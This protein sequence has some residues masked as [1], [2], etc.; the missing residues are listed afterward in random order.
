MLCGEAYPSCITDDG[1][2]VRCAE[3]LAALSFSKDESCLNIAYTYLDLYFYRVWIESRGAEYDE[4]KDYDY[5]SL[6]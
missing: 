6:F 3:R 2:G 1:A 5:V 4:D